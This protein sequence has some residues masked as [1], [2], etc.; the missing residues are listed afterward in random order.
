MIPFFGWFQNAKM[1]SAKPWL[2]VGKGPSFARRNEV[3]FGRYNILALNHAIRALDHADVAH[4][5]DIE[6][7]KELGTALLGADRL[8]MP[9]HPHVTFS[10]TSKTLVQFAEE[11][12]ELKTLDDQKY[13]LWYY[14]STYRSGVPHGERVVKTGLFSAVVAIRLLA[15]AGARVI[16]TLGVDGGVSYAPEFGDMK[17]FAGGHASFDIQFDQIREI[18]TTY[19][20]DFQKVI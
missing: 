4:I 9:M 12:S 6:V 16:R 7:V 3:D 18:V 19:N 10:P 17:P 13:L 14:L 5:I 20:L 11:S 1:A 15:M 2:V 8:V